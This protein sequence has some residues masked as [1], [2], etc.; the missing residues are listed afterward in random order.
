ALSQPDDLIAGPDL[1]FGDH[2][3]VEAWPML[4]H[5][6]IGHP[7]LVES[8]TYP[9]TRDARLG[10]LEHGGSDA[11]AVADTHFGIG[12]PGHREVL[13]EAAGRQIGAVQVRLPEVV[14]LLLVNHDRPL[15][16]TVARP[17]ALAVAVD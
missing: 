12:Q 3:E 17:V 7:G 16:A 11:V 14:G 1:A 4:G 2:P 5:K 10:H 15:L 8:K 13:A 6:E 9:E